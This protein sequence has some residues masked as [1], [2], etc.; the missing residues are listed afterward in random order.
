MTTLE[1]LH[2]ARARLHGL[3]QGYERQASA[4]ATIAMFAR[5]QDELGT[6][7]LK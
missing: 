7:F 4:R 5:G 1:R 6:D 3:A 2:A